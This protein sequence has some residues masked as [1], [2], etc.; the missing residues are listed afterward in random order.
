MTNA[1]TLS[2][3]EYNFIKNDIYEKG[4]IKKVFHDT[5]M[6]NEVSVEG[7]RR[8][9]VRYKKK[10]ILTISQPRKG[11]SYITIGSAVNKDIF[12]RNFLIPFKRDFKIN[13][14]LNLET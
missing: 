8:I 12:I 6:Y 3:M 4:A 14:I 7:E 11:I 10:R 9:N 5:L 1:G 2:E 13:S